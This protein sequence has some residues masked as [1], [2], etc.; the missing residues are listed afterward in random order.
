MCHLDHHRKFPTKIIGCV[1]LD[2]DVAGSSKD[3]QRI[4]SK[5]KNRIIKHRE[6]PMCG[7]SPQRKLRNVPSLI[8]TLLV[9]RNMMKRPE[10]GPE[11]TKRC[12]LTPGAGRPVLVDQKKSTKLISLYQDCQMQLCKEAEH[13]RVQELVKKIENHPHRESLQA[14]LQQNNVYNP[15]RKNRRRW[16]ANW[17]MW[18]YSSCAQLFQKYNVLTV[19]FIGIKELCTALADNAWLRANPEESSTN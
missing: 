15:F 10:C 17:A 2:S 1:I 11:S 18:S 14:D 13:L 19:F 4:Q 6:T 7:Q 12:V 3:T 8:P 5:P 9:K 16:S